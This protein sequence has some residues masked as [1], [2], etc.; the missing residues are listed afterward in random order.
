MEQ[1]IIERRATTLDESRGFYLGLDL[2]QAADYTAL[3]AMERVRHTVPDPMGVLTTAA[4]E[5]RRQYEKPDTYEVRHIERLPLGTGYPQVVAHV[6]GLLGRPELAG[7]RA[8]LAVDAT[9]VGR[10]VFEEFEQA[11]YRSDLPRKPELLPVI[12]TGGNSETEPNGMFGVPKRELI[13][14]AVKYLQKGELLIAKGL[15]HTD[16]LTG[17][18]KSFRLKVNIATGH[19]TYEAWREKDHD[20]LVLALAIALWAAENGDQA[21]VTIPLSELRRPGGGSLRLT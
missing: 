5:Y 3:V 18:L 21:G 4:P 8:T 1:A 13:H 19:D 7:S 11:V 20:D 9:G 6:M 15:D 16:T 2:G 10:P 14:R 12:I 17:E